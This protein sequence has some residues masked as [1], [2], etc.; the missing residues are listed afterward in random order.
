VV[1]TSIFVAAQRLSQ[2][3]AKSMDAQILTLFVFFFKD[4]TNLTNMDLFGS[5][6]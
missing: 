1:A 3:D 2:P 5:A 4:D 6:N